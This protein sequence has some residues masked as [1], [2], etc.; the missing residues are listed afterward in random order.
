MKFGIVKL[1]NGER[2][3]SKI[4]KYK[5]LSL[6]LILFSVMFTVGISTVSA[7]DTVGNTTHTVDQIQDVISGSTEGNTITFSEGNYTFNKGLIINKSVNIV[8]NGNVRIIA[9]SNVNKSSNNIPNYGIHIVAPN[10]NITGL[11]ISGFYY[12]ISVNGTSIGGLSNTN[13]DNCYVIENRRGINLANVSN[14]N[15]NNSKMN[16]NERE[17][18]NFDGTNIRIINSELNNNLFEGVHG[19]ASNSALINSTISNNGYGAAGTSTMPGIDLHGHGEGVE[20]FTLEGNTIQNNS[21]EGLALNIQKATIKNNTFSY[22]NGNG[23]SIKSSNY[24]ATDNLIDGNIITNNGKNGIE[25]NS[26]GNNQNGEYSASN[27]IISNNNI[28]DNIKDGIVIN[29][30]SPNRQ[31]IDDYK[32]SIVENNNVSENNISDNGGVAVNNTGAGTIITDNIMSD[33]S[34]NGITG[35]IKVNNT[36]SW[37]NIQDLIS[38]S[39][40]TIG[41]IEY[42]LSTDGTLTF[43]S[44]LYQYSDGFLINR[45][46]NIIATGANFVGQNINQSANLTNEFGGHGYLHG[47]HI[48]ANNVNI[49][50]GSFSGFYYGIS[51]NA[52]NNVKIINAIANNNRR[53]INLAAVDGVIIDN[54]KMNNNQREGINFDGTNICIINSELNNNLFEG[55]HG[56]ASNSAL[57]NSTISN[58]GYGAAGTSTMPGIDLHGHGEGVENFTLEGNTIQNNAGA[59]L[60]LNIQKATVKNNTF[61]YNKGNGISIKSSN[62][63]VTGNLIDSNTI[64]KNGNN[65]IE[66]NSA[67]NNQSEEYSA[68]NNIISNNII[69]NNK[70]GVVINKISP[71]RQGM[72]GYNG[73]IVENNVVSGN[74]IFDNTENGI[75]T[76]AGK[77]TFDKNVIFSNAQSGI[78][79]S[80]DNNVLTNNNLFD[81][82]NEI[83]NNGSNNQIS[84]NIINGVSDNSSV[85]TRQN[86][87]IAMNNIKGTYNKVVT[88]SAT[89]KSGNGVLSGKLVY[90]YVNG[91]LVGESRSNA[92]GI[93]TFNYKITSTGTL[94]VN[95]VFHGDDQFVNSS[96]LNSNLIVPQMSELKIKNIGSVKK[97]N[98]KIITK[99]A[100]VG[101]NKGKVKITF[102]LNKSLK[103][104]KPI[105]STG[106]ITYNKKTRTLTWTINSLKVHKT[107]S[108]KIIWNL[109]AIKKGKYNITPKIAKSNSIKVLSNNNMHLKVS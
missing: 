73:S 19:H 36:W 67:G 11:T 45:S 79:N 1:K 20:N 9:G 55:V 25:I 44:G 102:R 30:I 98:V 94:K 18:I 92:K 14:V 85:N 71:N 27:N 65:G 42:I 38:G 103:Y 2:N 64:T 5:R 75:T 101:Y 93:A 34:I 16:Y 13:M 104:K 62:Y 28:F 80:G 12:G 8:G 37:N 29:K 51:V 4:N 58:N 3:M 32:G 70:N 21:G 46:I 6:I 54:T 35:N 69:S 86:T 39:T 81:N 17:G 87:T 61:S 107:S 95:A 50:G 60:A 7:A 53:G 56:H 106:K 26:A 59:G 24:N 33:N 72:E 41:G 100:N 49:T 91:K 96:K 63:N 105:V 40:V 43:A 78:I 108:A 22:N 74:R 76:T 88:L 47:L 23:I 31:G 48:V 57:I 84:G 52:S 89:L 97:R 15:I 77:N 66:I 82:T 68:S 90:F 10:V 109:K 99:I 83:V